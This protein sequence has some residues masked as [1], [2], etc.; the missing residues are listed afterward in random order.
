MIDQAVKF[1]STVLGEFEETD[2]TEIVKKKKPLLKHFP[3]PSP[4]PSPSVA[5]AFLVEKEA[6][7]MI[8]HLDHL[9][10]LGTPT[11]LLQRV[12]D[13]A[14]ALDPSSPPKVTCA[15]LDAVV[16]KI[17]SLDGDDGD[18]DGAAPKTV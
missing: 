1:T 16:P 2:V 13:Q 6:T 3:S 15:S 17:L 10:C 5:Y 4:S 11:T 12:V 18:T 7:K 8:K 9:V 14:L